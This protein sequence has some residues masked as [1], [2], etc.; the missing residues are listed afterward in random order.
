[1]K[2]RFTYLGKKREGSCKGFNFFADLGEFGFVVSICNG[3]I[4]PRPYFFHIF[5]N[6]ASSRE[7]GGSDTNAGGY[8]WG[9]GFKGNRILVHR[10]SGKVKGVFR[11]FSGNV[12]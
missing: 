9:K 12:F 3:G 5:F 10:N 1:M 7:G 2:V 4:N 8:K 6:H 11:I